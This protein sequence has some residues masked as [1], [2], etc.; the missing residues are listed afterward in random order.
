MRGGG[1]GEAVDE[2]QMEGNILAPRVYQPKTGICDLRE[3]H[4]VKCFN[5]CGMVSTCIS[6][7][8]CSMR[9]TYQVTDGGFRP[10]ITSSEK[11]Q[12]NL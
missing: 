4:F 6:T 12:L 9:T 1:G 10:S 3:H 8:Y 5:I 2:A 7:P 11:R